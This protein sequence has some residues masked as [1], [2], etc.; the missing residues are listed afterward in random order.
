MIIAILPDTA[1]TESLLNNLSEV[2]FDLGAVSV[3]MRDPAERDRIATDAGP[4]KGLAPADLSRRFQQAGMSKKD[5]RQ[6]SNAVA[7]GQVLV[8]IAAPPQYVAPIQEM[9]QD[10]SAQ[11]IRGLGPNEAENN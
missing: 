7:R 3:I 11:L 4:L 6:Y 9:L 10:H 8:A 5:A 1:S 2:D